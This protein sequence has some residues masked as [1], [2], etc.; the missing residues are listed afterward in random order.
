MLCNEWMQQVS[1]QTK[2]LKQQSSGLADQQ[3]REILALKNNCDEYKA[4]I[5]ELEA[6]ILGGNY[7]EGTSLDKVQEN[8]VEYQT[9]L[10]K[11][12]RSIVNKRSQLSV[13]GRENLTQLLGNDFLKKR[14]NAL[15]LK[16]RLRDRLHHR[17]FELENMKRAYHNTVNHAKLEAHTQQQVKCKEPGIQTH[18][19]KAT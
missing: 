13:D 7:S 1:E 6:M 11:L 12:Q 19:E 17:K 8:L 10:A 3:I 5:D 18:Q 4:H 15:A 14:M 2:P 16:Q 9:K